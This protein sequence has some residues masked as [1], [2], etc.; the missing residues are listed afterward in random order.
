MLEGILTLK[1]FIIPYPKLCDL[2]SDI[3]GGSP[4]V[5]Y[6]IVDNIMDNIMAM[7]MPDIIDL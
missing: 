7:I 6:D 5:G 2:P 4:W 1:S 3:A